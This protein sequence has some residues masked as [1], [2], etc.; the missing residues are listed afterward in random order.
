MK[1]EYVKKQ[2]L[3]FAL[4]Y[5]FYTEDEL[6]QLKQEIITLQDKAQLNKSDPARNENGESLN[7]ANTLWVDA[8]YI[9]DRSE[10]S[11][12]TINRKLF[13]SGI[14]EAIARQN[15]NYLHIKNCTYD[16]TTLNY[17]DNKSQYKAHTDTSI[18]TAISFFKLGNFTGGELVFVDYD[19][20]IPPT[21][22]L[23]VI[24]PGYIKH[25]ARPIKTD[26]DCICRVSMAQ[27][28]NYDIRYG[29]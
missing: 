13:T 19:V 1:V 15:A 25:E 6:F 26:E 18:Y 29:I 20:V 8:Y 28:I 17:Y 21:E 5:D 10:S 14:A 22:N 27:F 7:S 2:G 12:L 23:M 4:V 16:S 9:K 24:F 3:D 11:I